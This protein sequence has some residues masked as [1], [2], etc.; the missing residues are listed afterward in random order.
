MLQQRYRRLE[1]QDTDNHQ[2]GVGA[3][4]VVYKALDTKENRL[5]AQKKIKLEG[6][7]EGIPATALREISNLKMLQHPNVVRL[8]DAI[9]EPGK[10][11]LI[12]ELMDSDLK[13]YM[14]SCAEPLP[15]SIVRVNMPMFLSLPHHPTS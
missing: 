6:E 2:L 9:R 11:Y 1:V 12:F 5:V 8:L 13:K 7:D 4:G 10:L 15:L 14:E 3:Y